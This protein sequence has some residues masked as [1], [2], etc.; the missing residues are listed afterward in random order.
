MRIVT[1][2]NLL[3]TNV[4]LNSNHNL[5][6]RWES[7]RMLKPACTVSG[8]I[9][10]DAAGIRKEARKCREP[11]MYYG[12]AEMCCQLVELLTTH[13]D[14]VLLCIAWRP[15]WSAIGVTDYVF[16]AIGK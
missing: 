6:I 14:H 8:W 3:I 9:N 12:I 5:C 2:G 11:W 16:D 4:V 15:M 10:F 7:V 13:L 1:N